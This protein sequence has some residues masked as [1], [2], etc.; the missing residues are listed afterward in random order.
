MN[1]EIW[2]SLMNQNKK[3]QVIF[4]NDVRYSSAGTAKRI[5][6]NDF[7]AIIK[8]GWRITDLDADFFAKQTSDL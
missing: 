1:N 8:A 7:A 5:S 3:V 4:D 2:R 6:T